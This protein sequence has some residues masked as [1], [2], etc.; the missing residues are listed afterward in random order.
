MLA[1][2]AAERILAAL[3]TAP[4]ELTRPLRLVHSTR[5]VK[6]VLVTVLFATIR[7]YLRCVECLIANAPL[8]QFF[9]ARPQLAI[10][11]VDHLIFLLDQVNLLN[12]LLD[13]LTLLN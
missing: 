3:A 8:L 2:L 10:F 7:A 13:L 4:P 5:P 9:H 12:Q 6:V 1:E 11:L